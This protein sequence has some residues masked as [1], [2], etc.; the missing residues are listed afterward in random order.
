MAE[1]KIP[2]KVRLLSGGPVMTATR[3][4]NEPYGTDQ[5]KV[6]CQWFE[7]GKPQNG[8]FDPEGLENVPDV[9]PG[10]PIAASNTSISGRAERFFGKR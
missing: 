9:L 5:R 8:K 1:L 7:K 10:P 2:G 6:V 3:I 4:I